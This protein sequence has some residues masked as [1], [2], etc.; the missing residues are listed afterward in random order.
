MMRA[1]NACSA[2]ETMPAVPEFPDLSA[3]F[4]A[5]AAYA[6]TFYTGEADHD[7]HLD[8]KVE[9]S[10]NVFHYAVTLAE[11]EADFCDGTFGNPVGPPAVRRRALLL[12]ALYHDF[13]RFR[14]YHMYGT[15]SDAQSVNHAR[16]G[17]REVKR[18]GVL[19]REALRVRHLAL[20][21]IA[22]HNRFAVP[23]SLGAHD[24]DARA[25]ANA[26]RDA[27]KLDIMRIMAGHLTGEGPVDPVIALHAEN[28]PRATP[29][30]LE[31]VTARRLGAY[32]DLATTTDFKLLV[33]GWLYD[34]NYPLSRR[35]AAREGHL[36]ALLESLPR[37][38]QLA[39]FAAR[40]RQELALHAHG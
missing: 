37:T 27:D 16:L 11:Q 22:L 4:R 35:L 9:H 12:A 10:R 14:Q 3:H 31:A 5:F 36:T 34:L 17:V 30:I 39:A 23:A 38:E 29:A 6:R 18:G 20:A 26:V 40:F 25:V 15:F 32:A 33:C 24:A 2:F 8:L 7:F 21:G 28:S 13:G 19:D 1:M